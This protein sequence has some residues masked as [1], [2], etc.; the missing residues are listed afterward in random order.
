MIL[1]PMKTTSHGDQMKCH[2]CGKLLT[3]KE[4][5][6]GI[7]PVCRKHRAEVMQLGLADAN[8]PVITDEDPETMDPYK[9]ELKQKT[10]KSKDGGEPI[11]VINWDLLRRLQ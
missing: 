11:E 1:T 8:P 9:D 7:G 2:V 3:G 5:W 4:S 10:G 6:I